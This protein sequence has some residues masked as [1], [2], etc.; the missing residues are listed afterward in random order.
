[1]PQQNCNYDV[2]M[3][4]GKKAQ[5]PG[6]QPLAQQQ[7]G[8]QGGMLAYQDPQQMDWAQLLQNF[9][10]N[11]GQIRYQQ[12][13][14]GWGAPRQQPQRGAQPQQPQQ[15]AQPQQAMHPFMASLLSYFGGMQNQQLQT[16]SCP[17]M[18]N[19][20]PQNPQPRNPSPTPQPFPRPQPTCTVRDNPDCRDYGPCAWGDTGPANPVP[21]Q[22]PACPI[23]ST[24]EFYGGPPGS[25]PWEGGR[26]PNDRPAPPRDQRY[27]DEGPCTTDSA[28]T[29]IPTPSCS[30]DA[31]RIAEILSRFQLPDMPSHISNWGN[32]S[33]GTLPSPAW[34]SMLDTQQCVMQNLR[35]QQ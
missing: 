19:P 18:W 24:C 1:M 23:E 21:P 2:S 33:A 11:K 9:D 8:S 28:P 5:T 12:N 6:T 10:S 32:P 22:R 30:I 34:D 16:P 13:A 27:P 3:D 25:C 4:W 26:G 7:G 15:G 35:Y 31:S 14:Q 29:P 17:D 20:Q